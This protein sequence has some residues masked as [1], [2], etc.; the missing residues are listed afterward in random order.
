MGHLQVT[1]IEIGT[2]AQQVRDRELV[3][4]EI[5]RSYVW[6]GS[7]VRDLLDSLYRGFPVG[8]LLFWRADDLPHVRPLN[9]ESSQR[10]VGRPPEFVLDGQQRLTAL[11]RVIYDRDPDVLFNIDTQEFEVARAARRRGGNWISVTDVFQKGG[12]AVAL[13]LGLSPGE[14][15]ERIKTLEAI[16]KKYFPVHLLSDFDYEEVTDIFVRANSKG[17]RLRQAE[18]AMAQIA[19]RFP[20]MVTDDLKAFEEELDDSGYDIDLRYL[21][22]C[23]AA[24]ATGQSKFPV[25]AT[26]LG[27]SPNEFRISW[28]RTR[29]A[30][31]WFLNLAR[32]NIGLASW[33]WVP[34]NNALVVPVAY[35]ARHNHYRDADTNGLLRWFLLS[36][37]WGR[38]NRAIETRLDQDLRLIREDSP[39]VALERQLL[40]D[41]GRLEV[42]ADD[43]D[44]AGI[45]SPFFLAAYLACHRRGAEDWGNGTRLSPRNLGVPYTLERH[46]IFPRAVISDR[47]DRKDVNEIANL[48]FISKRANLRIGKKAPIDYLDDIPQERLEQQFVPTERALW[49]VDAYQDFL[50]RRRELLANGINEV[51][52]SLHT[53]AG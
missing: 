2:L 45:N 30:I 3:L 32:E 46:H 22:R 15:T 18:L 10:S 4:P 50:Q 7:D 37:V 29:E 12:L 9:T 31:E 5:Q 38:Y 41:V 48:A 23:V 8:T 13:E 20:G 34:S 17:S 52:A 14:S 6:S 44:G 42:S 27:D 24:V 11:V 36:S 28:R 35:L 40:Q 16:T 53:G 33:E 19:F 43:L 26:F 21:I 51:F 47:Y 1:Q 25:L 39:F 49:H